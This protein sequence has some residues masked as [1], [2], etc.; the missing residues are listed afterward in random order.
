MRKQVYSQVHGLIWVD[1]NNLY[2]GKT[3]QEIEAN[4][5]G[6]SEHDKKL[7]MQNC[8]EVISLQMSGDFGM[9]EST[10]NQNF[11]ISKNYIYAKI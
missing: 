2:N 7:Y 10:K 6:W 11:E 4:L 8:A 3:L 1:N 5:K 9:A